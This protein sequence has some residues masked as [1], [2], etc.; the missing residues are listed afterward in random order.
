MNVL[1]SGA[2][3]DFRLANENQTERAVH[4]ILLLSNR[5]TSWR[6]YL[7][8]AGYLFDTVDD[9]TIPTQRTKDTS[10]QLVMLDEVL[11]G[12]DIYRAISESRRLNPLVPILVLTNNASLAYQATLMDAGVEDVLLASYP[13]DYVKR[14]LDL[15]VKRYMRYRAAAQ[16]NR[17]LYD[18]TQVSRQLDSYVDPQ[19]LIQEAIRIVIQTFSLYGVGIVTPEN[20]ILRIYSGQGDHQ[21]ANQINQT[22]REPDP[23]EP[24]NRVLKTGYME[25]FEDITLDLH[26]VPLPM[27]PQAC[28]A[29][30]VPLRHQS[31][32]VG[33]M[34]VF[35]R[36]D[37]PLSDDDIVI[38]ELLADQ[39]AGALQ[40]AYYNKA[41]YVHI[42]FNQTLLSAWQTL[43]TAQTSDGI[44]Q[45]LREL[46]EALPSV[47]RAIVWINSQESEQID[48][49]TNDPQGYSQQVFSEFLNQID[50]DDFIRKISDGP[51]I[52][53]Q[54]ELSPNHPLVPLFRVLH[55]RQLIFTS[56]E[57][58]TRLIGGVLTSVSNDRQ[59]SLEDAN[60]I[61]SLSYA[62]GQAL[63]RMLLMDAMSEK[64]GR[65]EVVLR[66]ITEGIFFVDSDGKIAFCNPQLSELTSL[67]PSEI[68]GQRPEILLNL[69]AEQAVN[70]ET[71]REHFYNS[72]DALQNWTSTDQSYPIVELTLQNSWQAVHVEFV[73]FEPLAATQQSWV[74]IVGANAHSALKWETPS[75]AVDLLLHSLHAAGSQVSG[76][77]DHLAQY[78][79]R[80]SDVEEKQLLEDLQK[81]ATNFRLLLEHYAKFYNLNITEPAWTYEAIDLRELI[82]E[83]IRKQFDWP[84]LHVH[85]EAMS[86]SLNIEVNRSLIEQTLVWLL[87]SAIQHTPELERIAVAVR[88]LDQQIQLSVE[89]H[90]PR[91]LQAGEMTLFD[92]VDAGQPH[93]AWAD[94]YLY[95][96]LTQFYHCRI[97]SENRGTNRR[98]V[99][100]SLPK[101][102]SLPKLAPNLDDPGSAE[103]M[104]SSAS[105]PLRSP[106]AVMMIT[107]HSPLVGV[108]ADGLKE[109]SYDILSY[110]IAEDAIRDISLTRFD[111]IVLDGYLLEENS[112][113]V[114]KRLRR[115]TEVP[116]VIVAAKATN[117]ERVAALKAGVD[118][119][120]TEPISQEELLAKVG[121]L[122]KRQHLADRTEQPLDLGDLRIDF[123][124]RTV[125]VG[126]TAI[127][128]TRIEYDLL[129]TLAVNMGQVLTHQQLLEKVWGPEYR[130]ETQYLWVNISRLRKKLEPT[131]H[132]YNQ[133]G[134]GY[135]FQNI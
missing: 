64:S 44:T 86:P 2:S 28:S 93:N 111:L 76:L 80:Y 94:I 99:V 52:V 33:V 114:Y 129:R 15:S 9:A 32:I 47:D 22:L 56:I 119:Y 4:R 13:P 10:Y 3:N 84:K 106:R 71:A 30:L 59:F 58:S 31:D 127:P 27:L 83:T 26:Y 49:F 123:A 11:F 88:E 75:E 23:D 29:S 53:F 20:G 91:D 102:Q 61:K 78:K 70:P 97:W 21:K 124:R 132:I 60:L 24:F 89:F 95:Y 135:V 62:A 128:L 54:L 50:M 77:V 63:E 36:L 79:N 42:H 65:L 122:F 73:A 5:G 100:I 116:V 126:H 14:R 130:S 115:R 55:A 104:S 117:Q 25:F 69:L 12:D 92:L 35:G 101:T 7:P 113:D 121:V 90:D 57:D 67:T 68:L 1:D 134:I 109:Q 81:G 8:Q 38:Y 96:A 110:D 74:G 125:W 98:A 82:E 41:Q 118:D 39:I 16:R 105:A 133:Q 107:G 17:K 108:L 51:L 112:L 66:S 18:I 45:I 37:Q 19:S 40:N 43:L 46:V 131:N 48:V 85:F 72:M 120:I 103:D 6:T 34:A 87:E